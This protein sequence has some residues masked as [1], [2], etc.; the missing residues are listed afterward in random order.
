MAM[1]RWRFL[2]A[3]ASARV[4]V[5]SSVL[6]LAAS[7]GG[8]VAAGVLGC[9]RMD[10]VGLTV[11]MLFFFL[12]FSLVGGE[13]FIDCVFLCSRVPMLDKT[14]TCSANNARRLKL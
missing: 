14:C 13:V 6:S 1:S 11:A 3:A 8:D 12:F 5:S 10:F 9:L 7:F 2:R 4:F